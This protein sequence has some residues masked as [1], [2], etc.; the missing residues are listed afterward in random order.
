MQNFAIFDTSPIPYAI[1]SG[2]ALTIAFLR[3]TQ[4]ADF[5]AQ[6]LAM[7]ASMKRLIDILV[8]AVLLVIFAAPMLLVALGVWLTMGSPVLFR[9]RRIGQGEKEFEVLKFRS[10]RN[11]VRPDG[12]PR[13]DH[14]RLTAFGKFLR[15]TSLDELPQLWNVFRG[16][17]SLVGPRPLLPEYLPYYKPAERK[18]HEVRPGITGWAQVK[19]RNQASWDDRLAADVFYVE[20]MSPLLDFQIALLTLKKVF[21]GSGTEFEQGNSDT[22]RLSYQRRQDAPPPA[23][24]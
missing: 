21:A 24:I 2:A 11:S 7:Y 20:R 4:R 23:A 13:L 14:E 18:R 19:H 10:M 15:K 17:M 6:S 9:Q 16:D 3:E 8:S 12:R 1:L 22:V 5:F